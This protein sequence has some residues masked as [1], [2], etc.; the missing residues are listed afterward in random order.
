MRVIDENG[1]QIGILSKTEALQLAR[2][3][4]LDLVEVSPH[5]KPPV[6]KL[7]DFKKFKYQQ[8]KKARE[9]RKKAKVDLKQV[10]F[11]PFIAEGDLLNR[12]EK[13]KKFLQDGDRVKIVVKFVG[14]QITR[15][16]FGYNLINKIINQLA[17]LATPEGEPRLQGKQLYLIL[18][19]K[20]KA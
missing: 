14:R 6:A 4:Q 5:T 8:A 1:K 9:S 10:R 20:K 19:P 3:H 16:E 7:I 15:K 12:L 13:S 17:D 2:Q 18:N 11:T